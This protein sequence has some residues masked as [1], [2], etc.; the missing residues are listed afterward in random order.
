[1][2]ADLSNIPQSF[3]NIWYPDPEFVTK[4]GRVNLKGQPMLYCSTEQVTPIYEC[5][6]EKDDY[7]AIIQYSICKDKELIGYMVGNNFEPEDLNEVGKINN[8]IINDFI[9][10]E[11]TKPVGIGTEYLYKISNVIAHNFMDMPFADAYVYPSIANYKKGWNVAIKP[12][13]ADEKISFDCVLVCRSKGFDAES[14]HFFEV[15]HKANAI[16]N[17]RLIY[18]F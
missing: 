9:L 2:S 6:I 13:S 3:S 4:D 5:G 16:N 7:Y 15:L 8:K 1:M 14:K 11:F 10:S 17:S 12:N 18:A